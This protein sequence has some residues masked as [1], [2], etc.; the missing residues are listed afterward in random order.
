MLNHVSTILEQDFREVLF[1]KLRSG[2]P[3]GFDLQHAYNL[4]QSSFQQG[5][6][7]SSDV[8]KEKAQNSFLVRIQNL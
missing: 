2:F 1:N 4:V 5:K 3:S 6:F 7:Q 8:E